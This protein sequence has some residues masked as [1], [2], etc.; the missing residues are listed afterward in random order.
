M[1]ILSLL[2][3]ATEIVFALGLED[4]LVGVTAEC[5]FPPAA[6]DKAVVSFPTVGTLVRTV[7]SGAPVIRRPR[8]TGRWP[9][10]VAAGGAALPAR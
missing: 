1:R 4:A 10:A 3:S 2:P 8:W 5:D 6:G 7:T 9:R